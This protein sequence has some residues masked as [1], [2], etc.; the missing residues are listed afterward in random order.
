[1]RNPV[2]LNGQRTQPEYNVL[3][4]SMSC[5]ETK[6]ADTKT[7]RIMAKPHANDSNRKKGIP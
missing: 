1:M 6:G 4:V 3:Y 7:L 5:R 2:M